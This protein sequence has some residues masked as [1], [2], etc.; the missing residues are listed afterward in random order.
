LAEPAFYPVVNHVDCRAAGGHIWNG[1][2]GTEC[3][4]E[5]VDKGLAAQA[6]PA[7]HLDKPEAA[8]IDQ[9]ARPQRLD[10]GARQNHLRDLGFCAALDGLRRGPAAAMKPFRRPGLAQAEE[11]LLHVMGVLRERDEVRKGFDPGMVDWCT[12]DCSARCA[13]RDCRGSGAGYGRGCA[14]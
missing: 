9:P 14:A 3:V 11:G 13:S 10:S 12:A 5:A 2:V 1:R 4:G 7:G 8:I 6:F